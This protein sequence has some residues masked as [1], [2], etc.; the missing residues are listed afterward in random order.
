MMDPTYHHI[1]HYLLDLDHNAPFDLY[2]KQ[3]YASCNAYDVV[4]MSSYLDDLTYDIVD[5]FGKVV[6]RRLP[7]PEYEKCVVRLMGEFIGDFMRNK[8]ER[9]GQAT[10]QDI[11][12]VTKESWN[13][14][15]GAFTIP[16]PISP[17][18]NAACPIDFV[19]VTEFPKWEGNCARDQI[20][21]EHNSFDSMEKSATVDDPFLDDDDIFVEI[22]NVNPPDFETDSSACLLRT[23]LWLDAWHVPFMDDATHNWFLDDEGSIDFIHSYADTLIQDANIGKC[24]IVHAQDLAPD[25]I[26]NFPVGIDYDAPVDTAYQINSS[27]DST[28]IELLIRSTTIIAFTFLEFYDQL[29]IH[30]L[31]YRSNDLSF[32]S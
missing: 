25:P 4:F 12:G 23:S 2:M 3:N 15:C 13:H 30:L 7:L 31:T 14:F 19:P 10:E 5:K 18:D 9:N 21:V 17:D 16:A 20:V 26:L 27:F 11:L 32:T 24:Q 1:V 29:P 6:V 22:T 28:L 8:I